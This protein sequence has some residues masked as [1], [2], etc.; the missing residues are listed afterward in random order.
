MTIECVI[1]Q[2]YHRN[3]MG[4]KGGNVQAITQEHN[5]SI[6]F[7]ERS[8]RQNPSSSAASQGDKPVENGGGGEG[9]E[10]QEDKVNPRDVIIITGRSENAEAAKQALM[11]SFSLLY[12]CAVI[13]VH[14]YL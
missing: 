11:A 8:S 14:V 3:I 2:K 5:V 6:K 12:M 7:P 10:E 4:A 1:E 13:H 9:E